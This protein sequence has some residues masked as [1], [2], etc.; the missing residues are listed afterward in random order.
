LVISADV[1]PQDG[2]TDEQ[3]QERKNANAAWA[4]RRQQELTIAA[5]SAGQPPANAG[6]VN[7]NIGQ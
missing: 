5:P 2:E 1:P 4:I 6:Q 3:R 7:V